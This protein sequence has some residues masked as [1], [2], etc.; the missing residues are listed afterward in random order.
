[1]MKKQRDQPGF[2]YSS[3][4]RGNVA[5]PSYGYG[6][7]PSSFGTLLPN[8]GQGHGAPLRLGLSY[9]QFGTRPASGLQLDITALPNMGLNHPPTVPRERPQ[10][11]A[12]AR[13][14]K[15][16]SSDS[17]TL[18]KLREMNHGS[19]HRGIYGRRFSTDDKILL[20]KHPRPPLGDVNPPEKSSAKGLTP[21]NRPPSSYRP[22]EAPSRKVYSTLPPIGSENVEP[23]E[24]ESV[25]NRD[26]TSE[27]NS[28]SG[29]LSCSEDEVKI[30]NS[31]NRQMKK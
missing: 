28:Q 10:T 3:Y 1:M 4:T 2:G 26:N 11:Q 24:M 29:S 20:A 5:A 22:G 27:S 25:E 6:N 17:A 7:T 21:L 19:S 13:L 18:D 30:H 23:P 15:S 12:Q 31:C 14:H 16:S 9:G 8:I